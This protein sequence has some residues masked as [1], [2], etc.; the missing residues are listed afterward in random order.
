MPWPVRSGRSCAGTSGWE[1]S[2]G[3]VSC[4]TESLRIDLFAY[5]CTVESGELCLKEHV[6][7]Q[8]AP[9]DELR[10]LRFTEADRQ[11]LPFLEELYPTGG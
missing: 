2:S 9:V 8:W 4:R 11:L 7:F 1:G 5:W 3:R 10:H 6:D